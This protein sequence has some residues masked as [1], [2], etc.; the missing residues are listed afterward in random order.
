LWAPDPFSPKEDQMRSRLRTAPRLAVLVLGCIA[1]LPADAAA[2]FGVYDALARRF[3]DVSFYGNVGGLWPR[4]DDV[5]ADRLTSFGIEVLVEIG[6]V[7]RPVGPAVRRDTAAITW[8]EMQVI[9]TATG[10]DTVYTYQVRPVAAVQPM[11]TIWLFELGLGYGQTTGFRARSDQLDLRGALRDLPAVSLYAIHEPTGGYFGVRSGYMR[12]QGLQV[13]D[14]EGRAFNGEA[15]SFSTGLVLGHAAS[16]L[17][18]GIFLESAYTFRPFPSIR[19]SG[20]PPLPPDIPRSLSLH[21][22][23]VGA[24]IQFGIGN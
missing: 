3:S 11:E 10:V 1:L 15:E 5:R 12:F 20:T 4:S 8:T 2:Q 19:W 9:T 6:G 18:L 7:R 16:I 17:N 22:W 23:S 14:A 13:Y 24:G 21:G